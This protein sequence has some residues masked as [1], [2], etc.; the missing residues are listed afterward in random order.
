MW[1]GPILGND[2]TNWI[3][4]TLSCYQY[5]AYLG[6]GYSFW[7]VVDSPPPPPS[8]RFL[9]N[10]QRFNV[11]IITRARFSLFI[12]GH[13]RT[14][15]VISSSSCICMEA[16]VWLHFLF[17]PHVDCVSVLGKPRLGRA[18][19]GC[20]YTRRHYINKWDDLQDRRQEDL[21]AGA[22]QEL[23]LPPRRT[24]PSPCCPLSHRWSPQACS[25]PATPLFWASPVR[26]GQGLPPAAQLGIPS[27]W[28]WQA[29]IPPSGSPGPPA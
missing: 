2:I 19:Q 26:P 15:Q 16:C 13:L 12:L 10:R 23:V 20:R 5:C 18:H 25:L 8:P 24:R 22:D 29:Q 27:P 21:Q 17:Q 7:S 6:Y 14:L 9:G 28:C 4:V 1:P 11:T 3:Y